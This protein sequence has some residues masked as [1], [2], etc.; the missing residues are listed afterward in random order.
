ML[1]LRETEPREPPLEAG[2]SHAL[3]LRVAG[4]ELP[5]VVRLYRPAPTVAFGRLDALRPGY[6]AAVAAARDGAYTPILRSPGGHAAA[7]DEA[8]VGFDV[9]VPTEQLFAEVHDVFRS[10][11]DAVADALTGLGVDARVGAVPGEYCPGAYTVGAR[12]ATKLVGTA[13]RAIRGATLLGGFVTVGGAARLRDLLVPIYAALD[14]AWDPRTVGAVEDEVPGIGIEDVE[15]AVIRALAPSVEA[16]TLDAAT[17]DLAAR[18]APGHEV[19]A[20]Q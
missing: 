14:L 11:A 19:P 3:L 6:A 13:Q 16:G 15:E 8:T 20:R 9:V 12:G 17:T 10:T 7:Y 4:G 18:L 5:R 1:L 2:V